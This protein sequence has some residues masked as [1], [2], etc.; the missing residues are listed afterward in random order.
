MAFWELPGRE[1]DLL[2]IPMRISYPTTIIT[3]ATTT[4]TTIHVLMA[5]GKEL[6]NPN[7]HK[8]HFGFPSFSFSHRLEMD[9]RLNGFECRKKTLPQQ[10]IAFYRRSSAILFRSVLPH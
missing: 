2:G 6:E 10:T 9:R 5:T 4:S 7:W 3:T 1:W 8:R